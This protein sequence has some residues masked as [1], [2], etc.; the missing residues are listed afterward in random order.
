MALLVLELSEDAIKRLDALKEK[1]GADK[2]STGGQS[3]L[4]DV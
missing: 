4:A 3:S 1:T 2:R